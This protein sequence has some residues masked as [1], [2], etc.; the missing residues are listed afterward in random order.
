MP[1]GSCA[2]IPPSPSSSLLTLA[3]SIGA[4]SAIF[5]V[6]DGV[7][8]QSL[9]YPPTGQTGPHLSLQRELPEVPAKPFRLSRLSRAQQILRR[10]GRLHARRCAAL[11]FRRAGAPQRLRHHLGIFPRAG[12][13]A[14]TGA[15]VRCQGG[16]SRQWPA[17]DSERPR[18]ALAL[19]RGT[20]HH[21]PQDHA[22]SAALHRGRRH[23]ARHR[24]SRQRVSAAGL[25]RRMW[26]RGGHL[27]SGAI[28][29]SAARIIWKALGG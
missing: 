29:R 8:I 17:G 18:V 6:I 16:D 14:G 4:N 20:G 12:P 23:A 10:H 22:E 2:P 3:L 25:R 7:L 26:M 1:S 24:S 13:H 27:P 21:R 11:R 9:P 15:R 5:S 19:R 28:R